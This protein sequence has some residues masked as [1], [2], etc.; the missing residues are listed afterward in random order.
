MIDL[1]FLQLLH[2]MKSSEGE[3]V[4]KFSAEI[5]TQGEYYDLITTTGFNVKI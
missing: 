3:W 5:N 4:K 2:S 1:S